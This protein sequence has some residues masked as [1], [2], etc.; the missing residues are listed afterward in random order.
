MS[1]PK[2]KLKQSINPS[3]PVIHLLLSIRRDIDYLTHF[4]DSVAEELPDEKAKI[5]KEKSKL[6]AVKQYDERLAKFLVKYAE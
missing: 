5:L 2:F 6:Y 1:F 3:I 4:I